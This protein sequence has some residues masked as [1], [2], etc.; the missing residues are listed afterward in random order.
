MVRRPL[1]DKRPVG[2]LM[3]IDLDR[4]MGSK[5]Q[6][7]VPGT[8]L[9]NIRKSPLNVLFVLDRHVATL[10]KDVKSGGVKDKI[11]DKVDGSPLVR[12]KR[13]GSSSKAP[14]DEQ[15]VVVTFGKKSL[16]VQESN[17]NR[18]ANSIERHYSS[19]GVGVKNVIF[20]TE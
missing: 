1:A 3:D 9:P 11:Q 20:D 13:S 12:V 4:G 7:G 16:P 19:T 10:P 14:F 17:I 6:L 18:M 8:S 15:A 2:P 5:V